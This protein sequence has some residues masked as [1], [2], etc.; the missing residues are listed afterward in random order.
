MIRSVRK[1]C[2]SPPCSIGDNRSTIASNARGQ[3]SSVPSSSPI[4][5]SGKARQMMSD[6]CAPCRPVMRGVLAPHVELVPDALLGQLSG[7]AMG[8]LEGAGGV[9]PGAAADHEQETGARAQ[10][11]E[12]VAAEPGDVVGG[13]VEVDRVAA[14]APADRRDVVDPRE[15]EG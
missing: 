3:S 10:P 6:L 7:E 8:L 15:A 4:R 11:V 13:V 9:L 12:V 5:C 14:L 1:T 2:R